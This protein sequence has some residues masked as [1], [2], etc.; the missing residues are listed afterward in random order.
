MIGEA[1][2]E[3]GSG[4]RRDFARRPAC[5][6]LVASERAEVPARALRGPRPPRRK[7]RSRI[8]MTSHDRHRIR[9]GPRPHLR[10]H[11]PRRRAVARRHDDARREAAD[12]GAA[13]RDGRRHHRGGLPDRLRRRLRG[14]QRHRRP[15][16]ER[17]GLRPRPRQLQRHRPLLGGGA[18][19][20]AAADPHLHR[21][22]AAAPGDPEARHGPDGRADPRHG[23]PRAQPLRQRAVVAD[24]RDPDRARL[25]LP[26]GRDRDQGR[27]HHDQ[28]P[29]HRRLHRPARE[30]RADPRC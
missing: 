12:R 30:R 2:G 8:R 26:G 25:P 5:C 24:G 29:R 18:A 19:R 27:R 14:G 15:G 16:A 17:G 28:H 6:C 4:R 1:Q 23:D 20:A 13:R 10:H 7:P 21:H 9:P 22:L 11:A 3:R